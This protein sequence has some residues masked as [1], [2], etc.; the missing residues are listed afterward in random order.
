MHPAD[1]LP[2]AARRE[3]AVGRALVVAVH[4]VTFVVLVSILSFAACSALHVAFGSLAS[5]DSIGGLLTDF[6]R[7]AEFSTPYLG[8]HAALVGVGLT[9]GLALFDS[10]RGRRAPWREA[11]AAAVGLGSGVWVYWLARQGATL[12]H[13]LIVVIALT[14]RCVVMARRPSRTALDVVYA[15]VCAI[16]LAATVLAAWMLAIWQVE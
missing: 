2:A 4:T 3:P 10:W 13:V 16:G 8:W 7:S 9:Y 15:A 5:T 12:V 14:A 11:T 6:L 1:D